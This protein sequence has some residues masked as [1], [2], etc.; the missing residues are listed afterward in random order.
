MDLTVGE[1]VLR[2]QQE[3]RNNLELKEEHRAEKKKP[4]EGKG[5]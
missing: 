3:E 1:L 4:E 5:G 2:E